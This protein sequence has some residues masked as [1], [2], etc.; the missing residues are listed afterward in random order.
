MLPI[1]KM[2]AGVNAPEAT[3]MKIA[4]AIKHLSCD[5]EYLNN[6]R[7]LIFGLTSGGVATASDEVEAGVSAA[8]SFFSAIGEVITFVLPIE[9]TTATSSL[10]SRTSAAIGEPSG[11]DIV[12]KGI[13]ER[14]KR[15]WSLCSGFVRG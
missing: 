2:T 13:E 5:V 9:S 10:L 1:I 15:E 6:S 14:R 12:L 8:D 3:D 11:A 4:R 7:M